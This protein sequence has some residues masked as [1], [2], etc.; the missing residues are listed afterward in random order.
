MPDDQEQKKLEVIKLRIAFL[1]HA[2]TLSGATT[3]IVV[4]LIQRAD[5]VN[6][7]QTSLAIPTP[8]FA[9]AAVVSVAYTVKL[10]N[11]VE[12]ADPVDASTGRFAAMIVCGLFAGGVTILAFIAFRID[13]AAVLKVFYVVLVL[14]IGFVAFYFLKPQS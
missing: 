2:S 9:L 5:R 10:I 13:E 4:A 6:L 1:Q 14:L 3:L 7:L 11:H 12:S 8:L